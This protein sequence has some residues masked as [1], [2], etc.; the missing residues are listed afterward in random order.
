MFAAS[1]KEKMTKKKELLKISLYVTTM[2][3]A[4]SMTF[5]VMIKSHQKT[6]ACASIQ[7]A[8]RQ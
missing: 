4:R 8:N 7:N 3:M 5:C 2:K 1:D 6:C